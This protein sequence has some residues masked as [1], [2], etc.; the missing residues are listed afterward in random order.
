M[1]AATGAGATG[2]EALSAQALEAIATYFDGD[3]EFY[4]VFL[5]SCI[6]QFVVDIHEGDEAVAAADAA[7]LRRVSHSLKGVLQTLGQA[8]HSVC[9][10]AVEQACQFAPWEQAVAGWQDLRARLI[11]AYSL[12][13]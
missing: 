12:V 7:T 1:S 6:T 4:Q 5:G 2:A 9:A 10:K 3:R 8:E 13:V 11:S